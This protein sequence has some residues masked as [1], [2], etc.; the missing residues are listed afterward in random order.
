[1]TTSTTNNDSDRIL[2]A[3]TKWNDFYLTIAGEADF[4]EYVFDR[5]E[6]GEL[7]SAQATVLWEYT[8]GYKFILNS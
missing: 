7:T 2:V 5:L 8:D 4:D 6:N 3:Q 1:M